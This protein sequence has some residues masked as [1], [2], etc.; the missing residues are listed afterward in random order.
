M[1]IPLILLL[2]CCMFVLRSCRCDS[3]GAAQPWGCRSGGPRTP[4]LLLPLFPGAMRCCQELCL[5]PRAVRF[6]ASCAWDASFW[7]ALPWRSLPLPLVAPPVA[8]RS[9]SCDAQA[10]RSRP[11]L[12]TP[13]TSSWGTAR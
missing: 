9:V 11:P 6:V 2:R 13:P 5:L 8:P 10:A 12:M 4:S 3:G 1:H 7:V